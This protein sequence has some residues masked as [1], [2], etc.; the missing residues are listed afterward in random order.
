MPLLSD[1]LG[2]PVKAVL[3]YAAALL[4]CM[5]FDFDIFTAIFPS[6][7]SKHTSL[8][9]WLTAAVVA[10]GSAGA[11]KL[12]QDVLG[13]SKTARDASRDAREAEAQARLS[14]AQADKAIADVALQQA[15]QQKELLEVTGSTALKLAQS[16]QTA[17]QTSF[18]V[19]TSQ[20]WSLRPTPSL[21]V[22][23]K[24]LP[25]LLKLP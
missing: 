12:F 6:A 16:G 25:A 9:L 19:A 23:V 10:G 8:V 17:P 13:L 22:G 11:I 18:H 14:K 2:S 7:P 3:T 15:Q 1:F 20:P 24:S 4:L 5:L 21:K